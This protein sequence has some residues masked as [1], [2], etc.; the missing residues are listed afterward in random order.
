MGTNELG[1]IPA[2]GGGSGFF[3]EQRR[4]IRTF[5]SVWLIGWLKALSLRLMSASWKTEILG[6]EALDERLA[7]NQGC[8]VVFWHGK[9]LVLCPLLQGRRACVFASYSHRGSLIADICR[10]FG[11]TPV[12]IP[13]E[14]RD[15]KLVV[16]REA[17]RHFTIGAIAVDGPV[18]PFHMVKRGAVTL[19]SELGYA[20]VPVSVAS[21]RRHLL[22]RR[23]DKMEVPKLFTRVCMV[24]G[25][26]MYIPE[27]LK[28]E[29]VHGWSEKLHDVLEEIDKTAAKK[30]QH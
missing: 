2:Q 9:Y 29:E 17:L 6:L 20:I 18:G 4:H 28:E 25:T 26:P 16:M 13:D 8:I 30:V 12:Q 1:H 21:R 15:E 11:Y 10:R 7:R 23:W 27:N 5:I 24:V 19:A 3:P 22:Y 14:K